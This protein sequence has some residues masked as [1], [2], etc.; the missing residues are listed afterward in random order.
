MSKQ[1]LIYV[2]DAQTKPEELDRDLAHYCGVLEALEAN[3]PDT[4]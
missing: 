1:V 4:R 3:A 2:F